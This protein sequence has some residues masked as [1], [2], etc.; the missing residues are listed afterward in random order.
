MDEKEYPKYRSGKTFDLID[1][2]EDEPSVPIDLTIPYDETWY[3]VFDTYGKQYDR[4]IEVELRK[5]IK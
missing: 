2:F 3:F 1:E 4:E 5:L